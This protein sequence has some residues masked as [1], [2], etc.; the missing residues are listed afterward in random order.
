METPQVQVLAPA[1]VS[2]LQD[3]VDWA[4]SSWPAV[5]RVQ[6]VLLIIP[7]CA[8]R[9]SFSQGVTT[10]RR[11]IDHA[12]TLVRMA[13]M[14][15]WKSTLELWNAWPTQYRCQWET[16]PSDHVYIQQETSRQTGSRLTPRRR[17][18]SLRRRDVLWQHTNP[19]PMWRTCRHS[20]LP[21]AKFKRQLRVVPM[22]TD[23]SSLPTQ[24]MLKVGRYQ[25]TNSHSANPVI[26]LKV[27][28]HFTLLIRWS[29]F[30]NYFSF[31]CSQIANAMHGASVVCVRE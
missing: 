10:P 17:Y 30:T 2:S 6:T 28:M 4:V 7:S 19:H 16:R 11:K 26:L 14:K 13:T 1:Q 23:S 3:A 21:W 9:W 31:V 8:A 29:C 20:K 5:I 15:R 24:A 25:F 18:L 12:S 27:L 22:T